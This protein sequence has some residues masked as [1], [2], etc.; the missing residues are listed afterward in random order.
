MQGCYPIVLAAVN[1][2][3]Q[4]QGF[5]LFVHG[6]GLF[7]TRR[8]QALFEK[9]LQAASVVLIDGIFKNGRFVSHLLRKK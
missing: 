8:R 1:K 3:T 9:R 6:M 7:I 5:V 4:E 2:G